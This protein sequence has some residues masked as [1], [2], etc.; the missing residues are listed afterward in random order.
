MPDAWVCRRKTGDY[1]IDLEVEIFEDD[2]TATGLLFYVQMKGTDNPRE[3]K[4]VPVKMDR[5]RYMDQLGVPSIVVRA[6]VP[7]RELHWI[8][9]SEANQQRRDGASSVTVK[10]CERWDRAAGLRV[11]DV[12]ERTRQLKSLGQQEQV[13][14]AISYDV[15]TSVRLSFERVLTD[16]RRSLPFIRLKQNQG[17]TGVVLS[18]KVEKDTLTIAHGET[19]QMRFIAAVDQAE[20]LEPT[21]VYGLLA[22]CWHMGLL[23]R[24]VEMARL[25]LAR[26]LATPFR[27]L[28]AFASKSLCQ[29]MEDAVDLAI[30]NGLHEQGDEYYAAVVSAFMDTQHNFIDAEALRRFYL[31]ALDHAEGD[32]EGAALIHYSLANLY[33]MRGDSQNA[34]LQLNEAKRLRPNLLEQGFFLSELA[35][36]LF[37]CRRYRIAAQLYRKLFG[38]QPTGSVAFRF[39][40]ALYFTG[41]HDEAKSYFLIALNL[42]SDKVLRAEALLKLRILSAIAPHREEAHGWGEAISTNLASLLIAAFNRPANALWAT[43]LRQSAQDSSLV[44]FE[45]IL[46]CAARLG[47]GE[48]YDDFRSLHCGEYSDETLGLLD[49]LNFDT[50]ELVDGWLPDWAA[51]DHVV[52][53]GFEVRRF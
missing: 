35:G 29:D 19:A 6:C 27:E 5:L 31:A 26:E 42:L 7:T 36:A 43:C 28:A 12:L 53:G 44:I 40:D 13:C 4:R 17:G 18:I 25:C 34:F 22:A 10:L 41:K 48:A 49:A 23:D 46:I 47:G 52:E 9:S 2:G 3:A 32:D 45:D 24:V 21:L 1:G 15:P 33:M 50:R 30:Q 39:A 8:W 37:E 11:R 16:I 20:V 38:S 14:L 51:A